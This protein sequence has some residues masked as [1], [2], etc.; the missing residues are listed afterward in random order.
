MRFVGLATAIATVALLTVVARAQTQAPVDSMHIQG[1]S[2][3]TWGGPE[4]SVMQ[5]TGPVIIDLDKTRLS[6]ERAVIWLHPVAGMVGDQQQAEISL[7]GNAIIRQGET[8]RSGGSLFVT[9]TVKGSIRVTATDRSAEDLS[10]SELYQSAD[11]IRQANQRLTVAAAPAPTAA[12]PTNQVQFATPVTPVPLTAPVIPPPTNDVR[13]RADEVVPAQTPDGTMAITLGG[14]LMLTVDR[15]KGERI[16]MQAERMVVF[17][18]SKDAAE[19][20]QM[21]P[22]QTFRDKIQAVYME[23]DVRLDYTP[24]EGSRS[25][26]N[27]MTAERAY[28]ELATD[29]AVLTDA[30]FHTVDPKT[31]TPIVMRADTLKQLATD[32]YKGEGIRMTTSTFANPS[33]A[34]A[35]S[36]AYVTREDS[37]DPRLGN[38]YNFHAWNVRPQFFGID[39]FYLPVAGGSIT[40]HGFPLRD[41]QITGSNHFGTGIE[42][43]W[44]FFES[45]GMPAPKDLDISYRLDYFSDRGPAAGIN[46]K[47][48]GGFITETTRQPWNFSGDVKSYFVWDHGVDKLSANRADVEPQE[49]LRGRFLW[50][51]QHFLPDNWQVQLRASYVSDA[52]FLEEWFPREYTDGLPEDL[53][54]YFKRQQDSE[55]LTLTINYQPNQIIT[56]AEYVQEQFEVARL[57]EI[58]YHR[59]GD[60]LADDSL[61]FFSDNS[62]GAYK[63]QRSSAS[64]SEQGFRDDQTPGIPAEG[65]TGTAGSVTYRGDFREEIDYPVNTGHFKLVP[66]VMARMTNYSAS[67]S[68]GVQNRLF[69]GGGFKLNTSFWSVNDA[70][71]SELFDVHRVRHVIEPELNIFTSA[72]TT[73]RNSVYIY[74]EQVD[75]IHD[76][77]AINLALN[78]RWQT[79]RGG[80]GR[81]RSVDFFTFNVQ[82]NFFFNK[83]PDHEMEPS[84]F[85]GLFFPSLPETSIPRDSVNADASWRVSDDVVI[86]GDVQ[87][88]VEEKTL[89]TAAV[90][91]AVRHDERLSYT[92]GNSYINELDSNITSVG[93]QYNI[94][95]KYELGYY[96]SF[97]FGR[98]ENVNFGTTLTRKFDTFAIVFRVN[99]DQITGESSAGVSLTPQGIGGGFGTDQASAFAAPKR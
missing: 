37:G 77:S 19:A 24:P 72:Q 51:H 91:L 23:G 33:F 36:S 87:Y 34:V 6:A 79:K 53:S 70:A 69:M 15:G 41:L 22:G 61:T 10:K 2:A 49:T 86:L 44:G 83:P 5:L 13:F 59:I 30:V 50:E 64:L 62:V 28:Y 52:N 45:A 93:V 20:R 47:Y 9:A 11:K 38:R 46:A 92:V 99:H 18:K 80:P 55:A 63:F 60:S 73:D 88:N 8:T 1:I 65:Q 68:E 81:W 57:P 89:A 96:Q 85:R 54:A 7:L 35:A 98:T 29:R 25:P 94:S 76:V 42:T 31:Q 48:A 84:A 12:V 78:Q 66:Y 4:L 32:Q 21:L 39:A 27:R 56:D 14:H 95:K 3:A 58:G 67:P 90:G 40:E 26:G 97:D 43:E 82:T 16:E 71:E 74:E 17:T 75:G